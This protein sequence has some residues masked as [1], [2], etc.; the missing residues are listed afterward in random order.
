MASIM[1]RVFDYVAVDGKLR[2]RGQGC[3]SALRQRCASLCRQPC[4]LVSFRLTAGLNPVRARECD[5]LGANTRITSEIDADF[6][7]TF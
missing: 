7:N 6:R 1:I 3:G 5:W 2:E 4:P